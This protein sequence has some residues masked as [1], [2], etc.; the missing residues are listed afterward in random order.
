MLVEAQTIYFYIWFLQVGFFR[1]TDFTTASLAVI[2]K[3][4]FG[5]HL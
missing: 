5:A 4:V 1:T 2:L 3:V